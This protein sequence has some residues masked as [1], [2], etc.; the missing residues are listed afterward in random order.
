VSDGRVLKLWREV[1]ALRMRQGKH[2]QA[3]DDLT[4]VLAMQGV[5]H[6]EMSPLLIPTAEALCKAHVMLRQW[7]AA[8]ATMR[9]AHE[10]SCARYGARD[11]KSTRIGEVLE[12]LQQYVTPEAEE[13]DAPALH[14]EE[15]PEEGEEY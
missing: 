7:D 1:A 11:P 4:H 15:E 3:A 5:L 12:S 13:E 6:G 9:K 14:A 8:H 10:L 2:Q